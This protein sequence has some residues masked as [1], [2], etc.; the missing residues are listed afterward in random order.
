MHYTLDF[1]YSS[2]AMP[3]FEKEE[4]GWLKIFPKNSKIYSLKKADVK[5][6]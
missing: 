2:G 6:L 3:S 4:G 5:I 1:S